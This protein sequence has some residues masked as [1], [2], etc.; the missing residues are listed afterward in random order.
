MS[1][2]KQ[3]DVLGIGNAMVDVLCDAEDEDIERLGLSK[4]MMLLIDD[5]FKNQLENTVEPVASYSGGSVANTIVQLSQLGGSSEFIGKVSHDSIGEIFKNDLINTKV[6]YSTTLHNGGLSSGRCYVFVTKDAQRTMCTFLGCNENLSLIDLNI[7][8]IKQS[9]VLLIEGYL[10][11]LPSAQSLILES[12]SVASE[13]G[14]L[15]AL[16][17]SDPMLVERHRE[18]LQEF[19]VR[20]VDILIGNENEIMKIHV[21]DSLDNAVFALQ[22]IVPYV[23][24]T[25]GQYGSKVVSPT[26]YFKH[27][28]EPVSEVIDTTGAGDAYA[29]GF[30]YGFI[31]Q[32]KI[33]ECMDIASVTA[34]K[35]ICQFGARLHG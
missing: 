32:W 20:Y 10:W 5:E 22:K 2:D 8:A 30:L 6:G 15:V 29:A 26:G 1:L 17:L 25:R 7:E 19:L 23:V 35:V 34:A 16:T 14:T 31:N 9:S 24:A 33:P 11:D 18:T 28:A 4:G 21:A 27:D 12:A 13:S 3:I